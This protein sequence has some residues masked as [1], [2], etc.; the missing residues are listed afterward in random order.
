[1]DNPLFLNVLLKTIKMSIFTYKEFTYELI[2]RPWKKRKSK[3]EIIRWPIGFKNLWERI[4]Y[5]EYL[6]IKFQIQNSK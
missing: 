6:K 2:I 1:M 4:S 5:Q 3:Y